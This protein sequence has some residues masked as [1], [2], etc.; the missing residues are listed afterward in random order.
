LALQTTPLT[1]PAR[2]DKETIT[3]WIAELQTATGGGVPVNYRIGD[4]DAVAKFKVVAAWLNSNSVALTQHPQID[5]EDLPKFIIA[6]I[7]A[8]NAHNGYYANGAVKPT[9]G[10][11]A[12]TTSAHATPTTVTF[13]GTNFPFPKPATTSVSVN[14]SDGTVWANPT[15]TS[16][17]T[18]TASASDATAAGAG[19]VTLTINDGVNVTTL[20]QP[21][22][23]T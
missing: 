17:T 16:A 7:A 5:H 8:V 18:I 11:V 21:Y 6:A 13:T 12:P 2:I 22:T 20:T 14:F 9:L 19:T 23:F 4:Q 10:S 3:K 1:L 15:V